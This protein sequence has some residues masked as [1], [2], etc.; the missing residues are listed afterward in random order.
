MQNPIPFK[1]QRASAVIPFAMLCAALV[2]T[3]I[4]TKV[5]LM[6]RPVPRQMTAE[7]VKGQSAQGEPEPPPPSPMEGKPVPDFALP[8]LNGKMVK[9]ADLRGK[10]LFINIWATWCAPCREEMPSL[11][12]L[13]KKLKGPNFEMVGISIDKDGKKSVEPFVKQ[14]G[15]TFPILLDPASATAAKFQI[16]GVP[17]TF[18]VSQEGIVLHHLIGPTQWDKQSIADALKNLVEKRFSSG[19]TP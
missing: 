16:T 11:E 13:Y 4:F 2:M 7:E 15:I 10:V 17:E 1:E 5:I 3:Y 8:D 9:L 14:L 19:T 6:N 12:N 18:L